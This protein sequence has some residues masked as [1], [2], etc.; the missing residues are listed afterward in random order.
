LSSD[1]RMTKKK[2]TPLEDPPTASS[3]DDDQV[4]ALS[5]DDEKN[6]S[7]T[8]LSSDHLMNPVA[9]PSAKRSKS[10]KPIA[11]TKP[12]AVKK[13]ADRNDL[14]Q[15]KKRARIAEEAKKPSS[16]QRLWR[17]SVRGH[18]GFT[19]S[20]ASRLASRLVRSSSWDKIRSLKRKYMGKAKH[21]AESLTKAHDIDCLKLATCIWGLALES[22][23][24]LGKEE[25]EEVVAPESANGDKVEEDR[26]VLVSGGEKDK[27][28]LINGGGASK[29]HGVRADDWFEDSFLVGSIAG[30]GVSEQFVKQ[31][32]SMVTVENEEEDGREVEAKEM[33]L[34]LHK[35]DFMREIGSKKLTPLEDPPTASSTDD[36][37]VEALSGDD[38]KEQISDDS[39]SD[40]L[41]NPVAIPSAKRSKSEK[42]IA[43]TKPKAVK[44]RPIE[45]TSV[46]AKR[47]RI[48]EEAKNRRRFRGCGARKMRSLCF[49]SPYEDMDRFYELASKSISFEASK[50][51]FVDKIRSLKRKYMGKAK[52]GA[53]SLTKAHDIDCLKLAT[54]IWGLALESNSSAKKL[55]KE[56]EEEVV[57]PESANGDKVE[58]DRE[59]LVS[60]GEK[61]K[62]VLINGGG[63]SK[64]HGVRADD[65]F[66]DSFLVGSIAGL[67]VSEQFVKQK[68]SMVT[69]ETKK[70]M[71]EKWKLLQAKEMELVL[72]KTDFM[73]R[74][75]GSVIAEAS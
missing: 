48:A 52:H 27:E 2:L 32:W 64:S 58:E 9:I 59:V 23:S 1:L 53:E 30:L 72:H 17:Q 57:A 3:T 74:E 46:S 35:T 20:P 5:G 26:E 40:H 25:E 33:E 13:R 42:P 55:G 24:N 11:V 62:E 6:R 75:I 37:Q 7:P 47:A 10:E 21:G 51:Q 16:F 56:E 39:S 28:V 14:R 19:N 45:T 67:G 18:G 61:D 22:N 29:S 71:E 49:K 41:M 31:K 15:C 54:C 63:A 34:V 38:E 65:W 68:W 69:V 70:R 8:I 12:K 66:E 50:I 36:D 44:K 60:G 73:M 43:V 4:E